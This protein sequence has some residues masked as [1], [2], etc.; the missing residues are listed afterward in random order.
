MRC[1]ACAYYRLQVV[2]CRLG[3]R[4]VA[5]ATGLSHR[6]RER[7][8]N[9]LAVLARKET[10]RAL[11]RCYTVTFLRAQR[12]LLIEHVITLSQSLCHTGR[13]TTLLVW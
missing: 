1:D 3:P 6:A 11:E 8:G 13:G 12:G 4:V 10:L 5:A 7:P 9:V 2:G